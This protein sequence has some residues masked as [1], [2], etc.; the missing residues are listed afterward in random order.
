MEDEIEGYGERLNF[1]A[2]WIVSVSMRLSK[3]FIVTF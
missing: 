2:L 1:S 3:V